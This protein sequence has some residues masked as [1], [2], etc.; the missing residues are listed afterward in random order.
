MIMA[1][2]EVTEPGGRDEAKRGEM[3][4]CEA[5]LRRLTRHVLH[6][7]Q[8]CQGVTALIVAC[9]T[10]KSHDWPETVAYL[11]RAAG[12]GDHGR[13]WV[14]RRTVCDTTALGG[15]VVPRLGSTRDGA[16]LAAA[17]ALLAC[18]AD[19]TAQNVSLITSAMRR[20]IDS[21]FLNRARVARLVKATSREQHP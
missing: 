13:E 18:G 8:D 1:I 20:S 4:L 9:V 5:R 2:A 17:A 19:T 12:S 7:A 3:Q 14:R 15:L 21:L 16:V 11:L 6:S 10:R